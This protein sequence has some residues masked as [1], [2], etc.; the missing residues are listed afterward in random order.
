MVNNHL[1]PPVCLSKA[2]GIDCIFF[3]Y[4]HDI[5]LSLT[6]FKSTKYL[7]GQLEK[8]FFLGVKEVT[9]EIMQWF[10][11][12]EVRIIS[13]A[14]VSES[15]LS[16][17]STWSVPVV[18]WAMTGTSWELLLCSV[19]EPESTGVCLECLMATLWNSI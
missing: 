15:L 14:E 5:I 9:E 16:L 18:S 7:L 6:K 1:L 3:S 2:P 11:W 19:T 13:E 4:P 12:I 8:H 10:V 17:S